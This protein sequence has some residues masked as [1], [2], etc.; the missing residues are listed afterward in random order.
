MKV[1]VVIPTLNESDKIDTCLERVTTLVRSA[2]EIIVV[3]GGSD[4]GTVEIVESYEQVRLVEEPEPE[5]DEGVD[6]LTSEIRERA[7]DAAQAFGPDVSRARQYG[8]MIARNPIIATT[9]ADTIP[10][11]NWVERIR[12]HFEDDPDLSVVWGTVTDTN[13]VPVRDLT[14]KFSTL[15]G[16]VSGCNTAFRKSHFDRLDRGYLGWPT[17]ED[18]ALISRLARTGKAVHDR[19]LEMRMDL[20]RRRYQTFPMLASSGAGLATG[21]LVG[22]PIGALAACGGAS[23]GAT[24][25]IYE[26]APET[27]MHHDQV[28][29][30]L[31]L[32]GVTLGGPFGLAAAGVGSGIVGH[33]L[34]TEGASAIPTDLM[35]NTD[36]VCQFE[37]ATDGGESQVEVMCEPPNDTES[38]VTRMLAAATVGAI[39]GRGIGWATATI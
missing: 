39:A 25:L 27:G 15:L 11:D 5:D 3:D 28:G 9:D 24:E 37:P 8:A 38:K 18:V 19:D 6:T 32:T 31:M 30:G 1:S 21:A 12:R 35:A 2:D 13:G 29:L 14:A 34:L 26:R 36:A 17:W 23:L 22:G 33:H 16:G 20:E 4:D 7:W 10:P